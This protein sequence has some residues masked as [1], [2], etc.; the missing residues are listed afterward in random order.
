MKNRLK[1]LTTILVFT[2]ALQSAFAQEGGY[3]KVLE[4]FK[5]QYIGAANNQH[6]FYEASKK[7]PVAHAIKFYD[8]DMN[9][10]KEVKVPFNIVATHLTPDFVDTVRVATYN[11]MLLVYRVVSKKEGGLIGYA[12][13]EISCYDLNDLKKPKYS[14]RITGIPNFPMMSELT[15]K[16]YRVSLSGMFS[17]KNRIAYLFDTPFWDRDKAEKMGYKDIEHIHE[18]YLVVMDNELNILFESFIETK[19]DNKKD[20]IQNLIVS[21][22]NV[23]IHALNP[24]YVGNSNRV[25]N[26]GN[27]LRTEI[28]YHFNILSI[29]KFSKKEINLYQSFGGDYQDKFL[30]TLSPDESFLSSSYYNHKIDEEEKVNWRSFGMGICKYD[31]QS[32]KIKSLYKYDFEEK[33]KIRLESEQTQLFRNYYV[34]NV[35]IARFNVPIMSA[36]RSTGD[37]YNFTKLI[38]VEKNGGLLSEKNIPY[39]VN[40]KEMSVE[41]MDFYYNSKNENLNLLYMNTPLT[42]KQEKDLLLNPGKKS[43]IKFMGQANQIWAEDNLA[44]KLGSC[45]FQLTYGDGKWKESIIEFSDDMKYKDRGVGSTHMRSKFFTLDNSYYDSSLNSFII[46]PPWNE[47]GISLIK[48]NK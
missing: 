26:L 16:K 37:W 20:R 32:E 39:V 14:Q 30:F 12:Y 18:R 9:F 43:L 13:N 21:K 23:L 33:V 29:N 47:E 3:V 1:Q 35:I 42:E 10:V 40:T 22:N 25:V 41:N 17:S 31:I 48:L 5:E 7:N 45:I 28:L 44:A 6:L 11:D 24:N 8:E 27:N 4:E 2:S 36:A 19:K 15:Y 38:A 34:K 46:T